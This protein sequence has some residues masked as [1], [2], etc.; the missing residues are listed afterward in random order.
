MGQQ[1]VQCIIILGC[2]L[3]GNLI[4]QMLIGDKIR[5][6][7]MRFSLFF[8]LTPAFYKEMVCDRKIL[9]QICRSYKEQIDRLLDN[10]E[11]KSNQCCQLLDLIKDINED[12]NSETRKYMMDHV[13]N[14][15]P[16]H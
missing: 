15:F 11:K 14:I 4:V 12:C 5:K 2:F 9:R 8:V 3:L 13:K 10:Y 7:L 1:M 6:K 16:E